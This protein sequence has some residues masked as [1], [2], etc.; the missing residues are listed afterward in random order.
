MARAAQLNFA[1]PMKIIQ[2]EDCM[3]RHCNNRPKPGMF[4]TAIAC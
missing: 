2:F 3:S 1:H 4:E